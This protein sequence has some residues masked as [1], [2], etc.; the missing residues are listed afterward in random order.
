MLKSLPSARRHCSG[1]SG[2][3]R[4]NAFSLKV[5]TLVA[6]GYKK[7]TAG[8][9]SKASMPG[10]KFRGLGASTYATESNNSSIFV[11]VSQSLN[12]ALKK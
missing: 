3:H 7:T 9:A 10:P 8:E 1:G 11:T 6:S 2:F 5:R 4:Y 12:I